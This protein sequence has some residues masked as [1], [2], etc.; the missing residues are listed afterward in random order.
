MAIFCIPKISIEKLKSSALKGEVD[1]KKLYDMSS[2]ERRDLFT[3]YTDKG[4]GQFINAEFEK[5]M[6]S[7]QK[8]AMTN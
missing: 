6:I 1:I 2:Q 5:A 8:N 3:K 7:K 4:L